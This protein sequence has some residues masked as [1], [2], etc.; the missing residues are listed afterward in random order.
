MHVWIDR[1]L[2]IVLDLL[3]NPGSRSETAVLGAAA[4]ISMGLVMAL[5]SA[6]VGIT[7]IGWPRRVLGMAVGVVVMLLKYNSNEVLPLR[8]GP[9]TAA[10][11]R[12]VRLHRL[13]SRLSSPPRP[14]NWR[15]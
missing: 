3:G 15:G 7:H 9:I 8:R 10:F 4:V 12:G 14:K 13:K 6:A 11:C 5:A 2:E 1:A